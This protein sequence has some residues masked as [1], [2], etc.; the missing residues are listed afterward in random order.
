MIDIYGATREEMF[1]LFEKENISKNKIKAYEQ[2][3]EWVGDKGYMRSLILRGF[4]EDWHKEMRLHCNEDC[5]LVCDCGVVVSGMCVMVNAI[6]SLGDYAYTKDG[7]SYDAIEE[8]D[9]KRQTLICPCG[10]EMQVNLWREEAPGLD[11]KEQLGGT[12]KAAL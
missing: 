8:W 12:F 6:V 1:A 4:I 7:I 3:K 10:A 9:Y 11:F 5:E 2:T